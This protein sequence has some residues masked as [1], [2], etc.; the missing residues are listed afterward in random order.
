MFLL[1]LGPLILF[2]HGAGGLGNDN[3]KNLESPLI[4]EWAGK[5]RQ[6]RNPSFILAPQIPITKN[7]IGENGKPRTGIMKVHIRAIHEIIDNLEQE[8][9]I[10]TD[11]E[12]IT[13]LSMGGECT[14]LS[15]IE[16]P[17][18][19][20]AAVPICGGDWI[21]DMK[22]KEIGE[23]FS[24]LPIWVF[25]GDED[26]IVSVEVSRKFVKALQDAGGNPKY[27]EYKGVDHDSWSLAYRDNELIDWFFSQSK[28][29]N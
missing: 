21:I 16:R 9:S 12:Y 24:K 17:D 5:E 23:K 25:H 13:G 10:D 11:R 2:H 14:W 15:L 18:R 3:I 22:A 27:T 4:S 7:F 26:E 19:F 1:F 20:A 6:M 28:I 29:K 8:F